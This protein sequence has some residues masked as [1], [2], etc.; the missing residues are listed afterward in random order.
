MSACPTFPAGYG[1]YI[2]QLLQHA[3]RATAR[4]GL[5]ALRVT[6]RG[7]LAIGGLEAGRLGFWVSSRT[8]SCLEFQYHV[9]ISFGLLCGPSENRLPKSTKNPPKMFPG[10]FLRVPGDLSGASQGPVEHGF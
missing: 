7:H 2:R 9:N 6:R 8:V 3:Q 4:G 10:G 5:F 1:R